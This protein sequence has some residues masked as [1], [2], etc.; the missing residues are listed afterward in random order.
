MI[1]AELK[2]MARKLSVRLV[3]ATDNAATNLKFHSTTNAQILCPTGKRWFVIGGITSRDANETLDITV[4]NASD[5]IIMWLEDSAAAT[6]VSSW[7]S[8]VAATKHFVHS[9]LLVLDPGE[10]IKVAFGGAQ[11]AAAVFTYNILEIDT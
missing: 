4:K 8:S 2:T 6:G 3:D 11:G 7:P 5:D 1:L 9:E 10:Y